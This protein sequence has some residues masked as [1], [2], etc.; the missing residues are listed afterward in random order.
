MSKTA[1]RTRF[2][3]SI[4]CFG[5]LNINFLKSKNVAQRNKHRKLPHDSHSTPSYI[6]KEL[7]AGIRTH[8]CISV[9]T[10][11]LLQ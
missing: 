11:A 4:V 10:A 3:Y 9:L 5:Q 2:N 6:P 8:T 1:M 7:K